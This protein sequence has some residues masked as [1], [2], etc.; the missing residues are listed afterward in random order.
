MAKKQHPADAADIAAVAT[1][2]SFNAHLRLSPTKKINEPAAT[3]IEAVRKAGEIKAAHPGRNVLIYAITPTG[4]SVPVPFAMQ[5]EARAGAAKRPSAAGKAAKPLGKR[6]AALAA[7]ER[8]ELPPAPDF[9][10]ATHG[11]FRARLAEVVALAEAG[12]AA[13]LRAVV[14]KPISTSPKA[15]ARYRDLAVV[16][17]EARATTN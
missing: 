12:D 13:G 4:A 8:G 10:A 9:S 3:L 2:V 16:A 5:D 14:I 7:A 6:A 1:A 17:L 15:I 11:R